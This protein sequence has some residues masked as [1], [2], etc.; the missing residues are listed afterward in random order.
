MMVLYLRNS[1]NHPNRR[2]SN[3]Q[4]MAHFGATSRHFD[5]M[6][7]DYNDSVVFQADVERAMS[8]QLSLKLERLVHER[9]ERGDRRDRR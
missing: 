6:I 4:I 8:A 3:A 2:L 1:A 9:D 5:T 7:N